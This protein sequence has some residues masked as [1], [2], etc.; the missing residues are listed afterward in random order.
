MS[1][2]LSCGIGLKSHHHNII[3]LAVRND[4]RRSVTDVN[5]NLIDRRFDFC[6]VDEILQ[7]AHFKVGNAD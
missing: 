6:M 5:A 4:L 7:V 3:C 2:Q 1:Q